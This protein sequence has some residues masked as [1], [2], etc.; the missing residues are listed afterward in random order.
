MRALQFW[1]LLLGSTVV[2]ILLIK[3]VFLSR[4]LYQ[5]ERVLA[6]SQQSAQ[7]G[8]AYE[9]GWKQLA[10]HIYEVSPADPALGAVLKTENIVIHAHSSSAPKSAPP[11][12]V[13]PASTN[14][15][16]GLPP[17]P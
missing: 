16:S 12:A 2:S 7:S 5:Q 8:Q 9:N 17:A 15:P 3:Q 13:P 6:D 11:D 1:I 10:V 4:S 14:L